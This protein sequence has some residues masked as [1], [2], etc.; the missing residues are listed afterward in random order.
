MPKIEIKGLDELEK[1][2][3]K[4]VTMDDVRNVV[5]VNGSELQSKMMQ[6]ADFT[7]GYQTGTTKRSIGLDI[8]DGGMTAEVEP[9]TEYSPYLEY[10]TRFME[11]QPFVRPALEEQAEQFKRDLQKLV[12]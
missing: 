12:R 9:E 6:K 7:K 2:L 10:G 11:A 8:K 5:R 4:N 1:K 3:K